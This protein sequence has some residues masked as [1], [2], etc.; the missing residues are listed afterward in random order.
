MRKRLALVVLI[1]VLGLAAAASGGARTSSFPSFRMPSKNIACAYVSQRSLGGPILRCDVLSGL[2]PPPS[3]SCELDWAAVE[4]K[5]K[6][7]ARAA[8]VGD[9]VYD[10]RAPI[11]AYGRTWSRG[12]FRCQ[13][14]RKGLTCRSGT[15]GLF[16]SRQSWHVW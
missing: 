3:R 9:T 13:S 6:A 12:A 14:A 1:V 8:C 15:H 10:K 4:M 7:K 2:R 5:P 11:L 16:L